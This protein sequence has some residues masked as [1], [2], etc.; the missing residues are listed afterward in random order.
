MVANITTS[1]NAGA[2]AAYLKSGTKGQHADKKAEVLGSAGVRTDTLAHTIADFELGRQLHPELGQAVLH[3]S[4]SFNPS[5]EA[6]MSNAKMREIAQEYIQ[7]MGLS[8]TQ[9]LLVRHRDRPHEHLHIMANRVANDG[10]TISDSHNF[11]QSRDVLVDLVRKHGL[12]PVAEQRPDLQHPERL[13]GND[14]VRHE[15]RQAVREAMATETERPRLL[16]KLAE[17]GITAREFVDKNGVARG[18]SFRKDNC[19]FKGSA[20]GP[21]FTL[22]AI[23]RQLAANRQVQRTAVS[24][25]PAASPVNGTLPVAT[26]DR[27]PATGEY[28]GGTVEAVNASPQPPVPTLRE[29]PE[30]AEQPA[31]STTPAP[32]PGPA[33]GLVH[34]TSA[35]P[36]FGLGAEAE[37]KTDQPSPASPAGLPVGEA[38]AA[39]GTSDERSVGEAAAAEAAES[40]T[41]AEQR[42]AALRAAYEAEERAL[43]AWEQEQEEQ[44]QQDYWDAGW[45]RYETLRDA[46]TQK[47]A[48]LA[49]QQVY[50]SVPEF[51]AL[52]AAQQLE[53][54]PAT[55]EHPARLLDQQSGEMFPVQDIELNGRPFLEHVQAKAA[56]AVAAAPPVVDWLPRYQ[57]YEQERQAIQAHNGAVSRI[58]YLVE[59]NPNS[60]GVADALALA[61]APGTPL[62]RDRDS[63]LESLQLDFTRQQQYEEDLR[64]RAQRRAWLEETAKGK[65]GLGIGKAAAEAQEELDS[66]WMP[67]YPSMQAGVLRYRQAEPLALTLPQFIAQRQPG[68]DEVRRQVLGTLAAETFTN[69][70]EFKAI[71]S[72]AKIEV[73]ITPDRQVEFHHKKS[74]QSYL[75]AEVLSN[76]R[77]RYYEA[78]A[79]G[80][81]RQAARAPQFDLG[82]EKKNDGITM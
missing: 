19:A 45:E 46:A 30:R 63:L 82:K 21:E 75:A 43:D 71:M 60:K 25:E 49:D 74:G 34:P 18:I 55:A 17:Q 50:Q 40:T 76:F 14:L 69:W 54:L 73:K 29:L 15:L 8:D 51:L 64:G 44:A 79:H 57:A 4:L 39:T 38:G 11:K 3:I 2:L 72:Y 32:E 27:T 47:V 7:R 80:V 36:A 78:E 6:T 58:S 10:H 41:A 31:G 1:E 33:T 81:A 53:L 48:L 67:S 37:I 9:Y 68:L 65:L 56:E 5:D 61:Q 52:L 24:P 59:D 28:S 70:E 20:L 42:L 35:A 13:R 26:T 16:A 77:D 62:L 12:T 66:F 23:E 22:P